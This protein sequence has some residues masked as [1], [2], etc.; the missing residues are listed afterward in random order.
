MHVACTIN[1]VGKTRGKT[2]LRTYI[3]NWRIILKP[4]LRV[5]VG[6]VQKNQV[7]SFHAVLVGS[8]ASTAMYKTGIYAMTFLH[9]FDQDIIEIRYVFR[10]FRRKE[11]PPSAGYKRQTNFVK[12]S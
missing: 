12:L 4:A 8:F 1:V 2:L 7:R 10:E 9:Y 3:R 11:L 5:G 6:V